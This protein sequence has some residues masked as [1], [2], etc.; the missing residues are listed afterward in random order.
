MVGVRVTV[1]V[2]VRAS[3]PWERERSALLEVDAVG[4]P[5]TVVGLHGGGVGV[6]VRRQELLDHQPAAQIDALHLDLQVSGGAMSRGEQVSGL[7]M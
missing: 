6:H 4:D 7:A 5:G 3:L 1:S 2:R